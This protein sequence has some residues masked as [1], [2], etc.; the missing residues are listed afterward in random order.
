MPNW[1]QWEDRDQGYDF[2]DIEKR[3]ALAEPPLSETKLEDEDD[4]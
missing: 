4:E 1:Y 3:I 2:S